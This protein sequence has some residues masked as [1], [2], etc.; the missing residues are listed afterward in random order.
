MLCDCEVRGKFDILKEADEKEQ[1]QAFPQADPFSLQQTKQHEEMLPPS[2]AQKNDS[3]VEK[4]RLFRH[5]KLRAT[6][7]TQRPGIESITKGLL[8]VTM[9]R[10]GVIR[11]GVWGLSVEN[12]S[13]SALRGKIG[14]AAA[15][16][17]CQTINENIGK[18][19]AFIALIII[20]TAAAART[21]I[22][23]RVSSHNPPQS[24]GC[25]STPSILLFQQAAGT[26]RNLAAR[27][28]VA[29]TQRQTVSLLLPTSLH[30]FDPCVQQNHPDP[31]D[32]RG[33]P[34]LLLLLHDA[35]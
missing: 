20:T 18:T 14:A 13:K 10:G 11:C 31:P 22:T 30:R 1:V 7:Q 28:S 8:A 19:K 17:C 2:F 9:N 29:F 24:Q 35:K 25:S 16:S 27:W 5:S 3:E 32:I 26:C 4:L 21:R 23:R 12:F 15:Q 6:V 34:R 33:C